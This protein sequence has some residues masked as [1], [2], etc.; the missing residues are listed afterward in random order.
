MCDFETS[1]EKWLEHDKKAR[2]WAGCIVTIEKEPKTV[3]LTNS[4]DKFM[5]KLF[6]LGNCEA[7]FHN[8]KFDGEYILA[9]LFKNKYKYEK[10][11]KHDRTFDCVIDNNG[12]WYS[13]TITHKTYNKRYVRTTIFDS[14]K[15]IPLAVRDIAKAFKLP[16]SKGEIDY[17][18]YRPIGW[19]LTEQEKEYI[20]NDCV[21][22]AK[23][24]YLQFTSGLEKMTIGSDALT[25]FKDDLGGKKTFQHIFPV[26][27]LEVDNDIRQA[28][29]GGFTMTN[30]NFQNKEISGISFDVNSL[31]P[32][33]MYGNMGVLPY[34]QPRFF[35]GEYKPNPKYPLYIV[36]ISIKFKLKPD[37]IPTIQL[38]NNLSFIPTEY[39][40]ESKGIIDMVVSSVD[41]ELIFE[42]YDV[43]Y[44]ECQGGYMFKA[45]DTLF[46]DYIDYW[47]KI[48]AESDG[49]KRQLAKLM[50]NSLYGKFATN[51]KRQ[52]KIPYFVHGQVEYKLT[53]P[54][55]E[56]P[57]YTAMGVFVTARARAYTI[58]NS[59]AL[60]EHWVYS[61][62]DSMYLTGITEEQASK[63]IDIHQS[64][65]GAWKCEHI[66]SR[67]KFLRPKTYIM[68]ARTMLKNGD[69]TDEELSITCAGMPQNIKDEILGMGE[70][71][72]FKVFDYGSVFHGKLTPKR[73][74]GGVI[75]C[76]SDFTIKK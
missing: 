20:L 66:I 51:P 45:T 18:L 32:S 33:V 14:L 54:E 36:K 23:A 59:Q 34:G 71:D 65:L 69:L 19:K 25:F 37:H 2:V 26:I 63:Y 31:Y 58:R 46:R 24:L 8:E 76:A 62:T 29:R 60:Y 11:C 21:I 27:P 61:D 40:R 15:K 5:E 6:A 3:I 55:F 75:L 53:E 64:R 68:K 13:L 1:T 39:V 47:G 57:V 44:Y 74:K 67:A 7:Y 49:G 72:A 52:N 30:P 43:L 50:L 35:R 38:K 56:D 17:D 28:Y 16:E 48:K 4:L 12:Q 42:Q 41:L 73:F 10:D 22:V 70:D 9:Y